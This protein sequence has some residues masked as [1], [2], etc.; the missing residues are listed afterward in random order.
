MLKHPLLYASSRPKLGTPQKHYVPKEKRVTLHRTEY[1][2][3]RSGPHGD[4][5][6][7][8]RPAF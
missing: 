3:A 7:C 2:D 6:G 8:H 5:G 1:T 4:R